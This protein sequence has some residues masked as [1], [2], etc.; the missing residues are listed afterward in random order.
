MA[1]QA[2]E[3]HRQRPGGI[4]K[5][6]LEEGERDSSVN[7]PGQPDSRGQGE[8]REGFP[9][10]PTPRLCCSHIWVWS[11]AEWERVLSH[12]LGDTL[13]GPWRMLERPGFITQRLGAP[14]LCPSRTWVLTV[15]RL[16]LCWPSRDGWLSSSP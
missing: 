10:P 4:P 9:S 7:L 3:W 11:P 15:H 13:A 1:I 12:Y 5:E 2:G 16:V 14:W 8:L 6:L